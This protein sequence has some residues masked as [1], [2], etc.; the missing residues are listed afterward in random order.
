M[1]GTVPVKT[2]NMPVQDVKNIIEELNMG[3]VERVIKKN[4]KD[5]IPKKTR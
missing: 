2:K 1:S 3:I 5:N 4:L